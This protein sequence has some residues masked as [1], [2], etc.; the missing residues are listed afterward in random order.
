MA[1]I[2]DV[3][4]TTMIADL[5]RAIEVVLREQL[6]EH[7]FE[8]A[9]VVFETPT[10]D[11]AAKLTRPTVD[12][13][14]YD[15]KRSEQPTAGPHTAGGANGTADIAP[16]LRIDLLFAI[17]AWA[18]AVMDEHRLLSQ[19]LAI[20]H[21]FAALDDVLGDR[22]GDGSQRFPVTATIGGTR[23]D[24]RS[25]FWQSVGGHY[26]PAIDWT[27]TL[28]VESG[29]R[30]PRGPETRTTTIR[31]Q[32]KD[33]PRGTMSEL[34]T[35]GGIV[36]DPEGE[37]VAGAWVAVPGLGRLA[38]SGADGRFRLPRMPAGEHE[39]GV[40][41]EDGRTATVQLDVPAA[42]LDVVLQAPRKSRARR[43]RKT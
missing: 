22:L 37:P 3:P 30:T 31:T 16:P 14:L 9:R 12:L 7:G 6:A 10:K 43:T 13:F 5:D 35:I 34:H 38:T 4:E 27:V 19:V 15:L 8:D 33:R 17:T 18:P 28:S 26:K 29:V 24:R 41:D 39:V 32:S 20:L 1:A 42:P 25:E 40:R 11:W 23:T 21:S 2:I 36:R